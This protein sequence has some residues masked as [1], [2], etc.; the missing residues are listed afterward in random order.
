MRTLL[1]ILISTLSLTAMAQNPMPNTD[2]YLANL[3]HKHGKIS[4]SD[5]ENITH[6]PGYDNQPYF[7]PDGKNLF[8]VSYRK[9]AGI[10][11]YTFKNKETKPI[12]TNISGVDVYS[13]NYYP[14]RDGDLSR[15]IS[16]VM[17]EKDSTQRIWLLEDNKPLFPDIKRVGYYCW[18]DK[19]H[20]ALN[21]LEDTLKVYDIETKKL[22]T[23]DIHAGRCIRKI[24][25]QNAISYVKKISA[26]DWKIMK[27][28][29]TTQQST[30]IVST[31]PGSEDY[32]WAPDGTIYMGNAGK[33]YIWTPKS[34]RWGPIADF[35]GTPL[36]NFYRLAVSPKGD[37]IAL[38]SYVG[39]KP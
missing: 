26:Q 12:N 6:R 24:P 3:K 37:K 30:E 25:G 29:L 27:Y 5:T 39:E 8:Y 28:D 33:L 21:I 38:V 20:I 22:T 15:L 36:E 19:E 16:V 7:T 10:Y 13:P 23:I 1:I 17:V 18:I 14:G 9:N 2:I 34:G 32:D 35:T 4:V 11:G 31:L